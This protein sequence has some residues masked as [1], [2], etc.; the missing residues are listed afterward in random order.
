M[1]ESY[2]MPNGQK[3]SFNK[4][5]VMGILN[6]TP[7]SFSDG[8]KFFNKKSAIIRAKEMVMQ[9]ADIIDIGGES[10]RPGAESISVKEELDRVIEII[11]E[12]SKQ[13]ILVSIDTTKPEV[14]HAALS[15]G[16]SII[17]D[18]SGLRKQEMIDVALEFN[19]TVIVMHMQ[20]NPTNMQDD[21]YYQETIQEILSSLRKK[22]NFAK[23]KGLN[24][25]IVDPGI[26]FGKRLEDNLLILKEVEEFKKLGLPI[27]IGTSRKGFIGTITGTNI[28]ERLSG[29]ITTCVIAIL[30]GANIVRVHDVKETREAVDLIKAIFQ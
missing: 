19:A 30:N 14:A 29:S 15:A 24:N 10:S 13:N 5:I 12:V 11:S 23:S 20:G 27:L 18:I 3:L 8:G 22:I 2:S 16:A 17:N 28:R 1:L 21:P 26:G 9:G 7:D 4:P 6:I 25:L